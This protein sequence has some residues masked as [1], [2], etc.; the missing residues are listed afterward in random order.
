MFQWVVRNKKEILVRVGGFPVHADVEASVFFNVHRTIQEGQ[1]VASDILSGEIDII[2]HSI[3][4]VCEGFNLLCLDFDPGVINI[5]EPVA[6]R[7]S[8]ER[9]QSSALYFFH[10]EVSHYWRHR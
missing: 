8:S 6:W 3:D 1:T 10:I 5:P 9:V 4:V 7:C 2:V